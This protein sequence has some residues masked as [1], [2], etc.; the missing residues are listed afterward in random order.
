MGTV[1]R[2]SAL[3][4]LSQPLIVTDSNRDPDNP[5][6]NRRYSAWRVLVNTNVS[7]K[8]I[9]R[10]H[11]RRIVHRLNEAWEQVFGPTP[12]NIRTFIPFDE[13]HFPFLAAKGSPYV[14]WKVESD[15]RFPPP[16]ASSRK[17]GEIGK[18][19]HKI[20]LHGEFRLMHY[21]NARLD[22]NQLKT[23]MKDL[24]VGEGGGDLGIANPYITFEY[25]VDREGDELYLEKGE[26]IHRDQTDNELREIRDIAA[27]EEAIR[28]ASN[29]SSNSRR[30]PQTPE[31][32]EDELIP[33][34][35]PSPPPYQP[36]D[37]SDTEEEEEPL[38]RRRRRGPRRPNIDPLPPG[39]A[40]GITRS[41]RE[42]T[43]EIM[44]RSEYRSRRRR[45]GKK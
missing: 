32:D 4:Q 31:I 7:R 18:K 39:T 27:E 41:Q 45:G 19:F 38:Q 37:N 33:A 21:G 22:Y 17:K 14:K 16:A 29:E 24:I 40:T 35:A 20:H 26:E 3:S 44:P 25:V 12:P 11:F 1:A 43:G 42:F 30:R 13:A 28:A 6:K 34:A 36:D 8:S 2:P 15:P 5:L 10:D 9:S 23:T